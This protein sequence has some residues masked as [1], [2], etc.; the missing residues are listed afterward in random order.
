MSLS[1][2]IF[3]LINATKLQKIAVILEIMRYWLRKTLVY[4]QKVEGLAY[5]MDLLT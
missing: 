3:E 2:L 5:K 4:M 1:N